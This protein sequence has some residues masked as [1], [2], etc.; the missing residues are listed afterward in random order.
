MLQPRLIKLFNVKHKQ[1]QHL[2]WFETHDK[3]CQNLEW[4]KKYKFSLLILYSLDYK[5]FTVQESGQLHSGAG[6]L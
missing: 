3:Q 5:I 4:V 2:A 1:G 6:C